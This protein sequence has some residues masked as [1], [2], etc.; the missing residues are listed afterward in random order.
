MERERRQEEHPLLD[1]SLRCIK[2]A[3]RDA[4]DISSAVYEQGERIGRVKTGIE[5]TEE[6]IKRTSLR[7]RNILAGV[8]KRRIIVTSLL[9]IL[10]FIVVTLKIKNII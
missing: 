9:G 3:N 4:G 8:A 2:E 1:S 6:M 5:G 7:L 10:L